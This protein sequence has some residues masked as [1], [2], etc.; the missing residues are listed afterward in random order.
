MSPALESVEASAYVVP[1]DQPEADGTVAWNSTTLVLLQV[2]AAGETGTGWTYTW[3]PEA[4]EEFRV[5]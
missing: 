2:R 3:R 1:T 4:A 5:R